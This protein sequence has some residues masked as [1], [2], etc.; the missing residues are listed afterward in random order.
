MLT[1][2]PRDL[3]QE[4]EQEVQRLEQA[5]KRAESMVNKDKREKVEQSALSKVRKEEREKRGQG[6]GVWYMK[7]GTLFYRTLFTNSISQSLSLSLVSS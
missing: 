4:R 2:S 7:D 3:R 5:V 6:K 1:S